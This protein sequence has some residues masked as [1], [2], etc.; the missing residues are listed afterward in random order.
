M[1]HWVVVVQPVPP[2]REQPP[3]KSQPLMSSMKPA[4]RKSNVHIGNHVLSR[5]G[6]SGKLRVRDR[7]KN[8]RGKIGGSHLRPAPERTA[9]HGFM[10]ARH[11]TSTCLFLLLSTCKS[12]CRHMYH[13]HQPRHQH[14]TASE[15]THTAQH[16]IMLT[17]PVV[18]HPVARDLPLVDP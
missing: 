1:L 7:N 2:A 11:R 15:A 16:N 4:A 13:R 6:G 5:P 3:A 12:T 9:Q 10:A 18:V 8:G 14:S 17:I